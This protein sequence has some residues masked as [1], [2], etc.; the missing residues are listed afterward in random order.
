MLERS[1]IN[2]SSVNAGLDV[3]CL[4]LSLSVMASSTFK[5]L[6]PS[7][8]S[9]SEPL[10]SSYTGTLVRI[11]NLLVRKKTDD[12]SSYNFKVVEFLQLTSSLAVFKKNIPLNHL[13]SVLFQI[14]C[15]LPILSTD[16]GTG[17]AR[18]SLRKLLDD[19]RPLLMWLYSVLDQGK[20]SHPP[21]TRL[22]PS[23][24]FRNAVWRALG[25]EE[26]LDAQRREETVDP[27]GSA[28]FASGAPTQFIFD[29]RANDK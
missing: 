9:S 26:G 7:A 19:M 25:D 13:D 12:P 17:E 18:W 5:Q 14:L 28:S 27:A 24:E 15:L 10:V 23:A 8:S 22:T 6:F 4:S 20:L 29:R 11:K 21:Q 2:H 16:F 3:T 1:W